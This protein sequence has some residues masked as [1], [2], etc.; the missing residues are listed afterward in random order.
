MKMSYQT[1][2]FSIVPWHSQ[3]R[4][5]SDT[6]RKAVRCPCRRHAQWTVVSRAKSRSRRD[7]SRDDTGRAVVVLS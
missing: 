5:W 4:C 2:M 6:R 3:W 7:Q 1:R